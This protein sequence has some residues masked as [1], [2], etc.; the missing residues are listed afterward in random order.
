MNAKSISKSNPSKTAQTLRAKPIFNHK[1]QKNE[2]LREQT[3]ISVDIPSI[4]RH[5]L[6]NKFYS[7]TVEQKG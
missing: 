7:E 2:V 3:V 6:T 4:L 1:R 5:K